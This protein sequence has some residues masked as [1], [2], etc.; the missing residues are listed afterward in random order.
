[1]DE[2]RTHVRIRVK[3]HLTDFVERGRVYL[4][5]GIETAD[6]SGIGVEKQQFGPTVVRRSAT[7]ID[8]R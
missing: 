8:K 7:R 3:V 4:S 1:M 5:L 6:E 2:R